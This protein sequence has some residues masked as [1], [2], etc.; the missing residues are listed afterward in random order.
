MCTVTGQYKANVHT[1]ARVVKGVGGG[2]GEWTVTCA[3]ACVCGGG[4]LHLV[5]SGGDG[6]AE[7][8]RL[9]LL[10]PHLHQLLGVHRTGLGGGAWD[11]D[12]GYYME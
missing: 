2:G 8:E 10:L 3:C 7:S 4:H 1:Y 6:G 5:A 11:S 12:S 9:C